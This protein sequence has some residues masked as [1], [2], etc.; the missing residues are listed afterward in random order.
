MTWQR[1]RR[2]DGGLDDGANGAWPY[3]GARM[4]LPV[5]VVVVAWGVEE[6]YRRGNGALV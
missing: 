2:D 3:D 6:E 4:E 1:Q 5:E